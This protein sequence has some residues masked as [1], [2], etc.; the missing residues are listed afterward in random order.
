VKTA[1]SYLAIYR[2]PLTFCAVTELAGVTSEA[3]LRL[4]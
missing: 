4:C 1:E 2:L 3:K